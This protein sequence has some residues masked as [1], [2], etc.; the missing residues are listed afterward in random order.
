MN[1]SVSLTSINI[2]IYD[3]SLFMYT[4]Q[5]MCTDTLTSQTKH[6]VS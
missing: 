5:L 4:C 1:F 6:T 2:I 3:S